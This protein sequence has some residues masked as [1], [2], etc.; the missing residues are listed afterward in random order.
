MTS[1]KHVFNTTVFTS[2]TLSPKLVKAYENYGQKFTYTF[3]ESMMITVSVFIK[4]TL[5]RQ[6]FG[7]M[8][9][10]KFYENP[11]SDIVTDTTSQRNRQTWSPK[12]SSFFFN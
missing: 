2:F 9:H 10:T 3:K 12:K 6:H 4:L 11:T 5:A 8:P 7:N 1:T